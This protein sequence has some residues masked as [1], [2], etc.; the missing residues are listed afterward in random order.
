MNRRYSVREY[1]ELV[2]QAL[3]LMP[4]LGLGTD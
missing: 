4:D 1:E 2:E 3:Q